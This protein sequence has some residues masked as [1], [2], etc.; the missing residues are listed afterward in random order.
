MVVMEKLCDR[1]QNSSR[2]E[3]G[4]GSSKISTVVRCGHKVSISSRGSK[5]N[6]S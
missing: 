6:C 2:F 5:Y 4:I 3:I 1:K